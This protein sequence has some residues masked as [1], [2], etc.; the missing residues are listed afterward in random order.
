MLRINSGSD[1]HKDLITEL[2][3]KHGG[4]EFVFTCFFVDILEDRYIDWVDESDYFGSLVKLTPKAL[5]LIRGETAS[6]L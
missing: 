5:E 6:G 1:S 4:R 3:I 2:Y